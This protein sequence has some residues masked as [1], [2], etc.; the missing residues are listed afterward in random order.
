MVSKVA[1]ED[2]AEELRTPTISCSSVTAAQSNDSV[3]RGGERG[4]GHSEQCE[5]SGMTRAGVPSVP[6]DPFV[7]RSPWPSDGTVGE[8]VQRREVLN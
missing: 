7:L 1:G 3:V 5:R 8:A 4:D 6:S 2:E